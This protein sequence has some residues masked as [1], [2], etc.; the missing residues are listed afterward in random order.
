M[1]IDAELTLWGILP[2]LLGLGLFYLSVRKLLRGKGF[3]YVF[4]ALSIITM[5]CLAEVMFYSMIFLEAWPTFLPH[6]I[7]LGAAGIYFF[8]PSAKF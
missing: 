4:F 5:I 3:L 8:Q 2:A 1:H 6:L 7:T